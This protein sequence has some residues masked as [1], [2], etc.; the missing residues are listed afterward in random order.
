[1]RIDYRKLRVWDGAMDLVLR[2]YRLTLNFPATEKFGLMSQLRKCAVSIPSNIAEGSRRKTDADFCN[3][4]HFA[5]GSGAEMET[6]LE[7]AKRLNFA[8]TC[9]INE[10]ATMLASVMRMLNNFIKTK[11]N[12]S[13]PTSPLHHQ[14]T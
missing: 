3:F 10:C 6:Q 2:V 12:S 4:L 9:E 8:P 14:T 13:R 7:I 11:E 5:F 1:M